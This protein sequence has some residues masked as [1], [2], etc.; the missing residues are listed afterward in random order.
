MKTRFKMLPILNIGTITLKSNATMRLEQDPDLI[1]GEG[2]F[3]QGEDG[4]ACPY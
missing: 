3:V 4:L 1:T 2:A